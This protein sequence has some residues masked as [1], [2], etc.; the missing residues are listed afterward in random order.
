MDEFVDFYRRVQTPHY[1]EARK[2]YYD[3]QLLIDYSDAN[4][5]YPYL[6]EQLKLTIEGY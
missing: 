3:E 6:E 4:E 1:E 2:N 5:Y